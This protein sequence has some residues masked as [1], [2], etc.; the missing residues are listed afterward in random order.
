MLKG[1]PDDGVV[2]CS[3]SLISTSDHAAS[4]LEV[5]NESVESRRRTRRHAHER[6]VTLLHGAEHG[7]GL[8]G[9]EH[10]ERLG[11][12]RSPNPGEVRAPRAGSGACD[13]TMDGGSGRPVV[14]GAIGKIDRIGMLFAGIRASA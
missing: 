7:E 8:E 5:E 12:A 1:T 4:C 11:T 6:L 10:E 2:N 3:Y 14:P 13:T 9:C